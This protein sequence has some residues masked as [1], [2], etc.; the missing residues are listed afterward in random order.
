MQ[1]PGKNAAKVVCTE[2]K[3]SSHVHVLQGGHCQDEVF[4]LASWLAL[5]VSLSSVREDTVSAIIVILM[6]RVKVRVREAPPK[7]QL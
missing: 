1:S 4:L 5:M 7:K 6:V 2:P 3:L